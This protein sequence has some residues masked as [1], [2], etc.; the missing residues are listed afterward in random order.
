MLPASDSTRSPDVSELPPE[1]RQGTGSRGLRPYLLH[2]LATKPAV[3]ASEREADAPPERP[4][5]FPHADSPRPVPRPGPHPH[6]RA[7]TRRATSSAP[8]NRPARLRKTSALREAS[9]ARTYVIQKHFASR[10]HYDLR[11]ELDGVFLSW[12]LHKC[13]S[14]DLANKRT[15][16]HVEDHLC[17]IPFSPIR[18]QGEG[19]GKSHWHWLGGESSPRA[20]PCA[21]F[22]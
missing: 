12:A 11:F 3:L 5:A 15:A 4:I 21:T 16:I 9:T 7:T 2:S 1:Y 22:F 18:S 10:L 13:P 6:W 14:F 19:R 8:P 17:H 20:P